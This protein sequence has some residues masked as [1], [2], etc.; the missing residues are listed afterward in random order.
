MQEL[1]ARLLCFQSE[2]GFLSELAEAD[3]GIGMCSSEESLGGIGRVVTEILALAEDYGLTGDL[4]QAALTYH[5]MTHE[6]PYTLGRERRAEARDSVASRL[7]RSDM[8]VFLAL[9]FYDFTV[10]EERLGVDWFSVLRAGGEAREIEHAHVREIGEKICS[11]RDRLAKA[12]DADE[13]FAALDA[14]YAQCG[15][16]LFG[17]YRAFRPVE[18]EGG[19]ALTPIHFTGCDAYEDLIGYED[20]KERVRNNTEQFLT[21]VRGNNVLLYGDSGTGKSTS[22]RAT[23]NAFFDRGLRMVE[24]RKGN[25]HLLGDI[26]SMLKE[27]NYHFVIYVDDFSFEE[28]ERDY[29]AWKAAIEGGLEEMTDRVLIYAT[30][31]RRHIVR[32]TWRDRNDMEYDGDIHRSDTIE[33]KMSLV[34][35]FGEMIYFPK[36]DKRGY[37]EIV[38]GLAQEIGLA[39]DDEELLAEANKWEIRHGGMSGRTAEQFIQF[40]LGRYERK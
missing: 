30:S 32:E 12:S 25:I 14:Y 4:W 6:N 31:N 3:E 34:Q 9:F 33:E 29:K 40:M 37:N 18:D 27:R 17:L 20:Q 35:R 24:V 22:I 2:T 36:P 5:L 28:E 23:L 13:F 19:V 7:A 15:A 10:W 16:G 11:L 8:E 39:V 1:I 26:L 21:G 38:R